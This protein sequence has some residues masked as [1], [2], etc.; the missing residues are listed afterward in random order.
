M[1][2]ANTYTSRNKFM[3]STMVYDCKMNL[4]QKTKTWNK[5]SLLEVIWSFLSVIS[6]S[7]YP[8]SMENTNT[9]RLKDDWSTMAYD[10]KMNVGQ[11]TRTWN[12]NGLFACWLSVVLAHRAYFC[13]FPIKIERAIVM[14]NESTR[15]KYY[16]IGVTWTLRFYL[17][18]HFLTTDHIT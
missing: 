15:I 6:W 14:G 8:M 11:E 7:K 10:C 5:N 12:N 13:A 9:S 17:S 1:S 18:K 2:M 3:W 4:G 16:C